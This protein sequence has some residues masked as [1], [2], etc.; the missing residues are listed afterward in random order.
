SRGERGLSKEILEEERRALGIP[1][2]GAARA[3]LRGRLLLGGRIGLARIWGAR[4]C[5]G[6]RR[7]RRRRRGRQGGRRVGRR[8][9][10]RGGAAA[11]P[12]GIVGPAAPTPDRPA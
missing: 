11:R 10:G 5:S 6:L 7:G 3:A 2:T 12:A 9:L 4:S 1:G 8:R